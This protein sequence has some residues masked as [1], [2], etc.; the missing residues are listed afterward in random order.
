MR[1]L[2]GVRGWGS[3]AAAVTA[4]VACSIAGKQ[5]VE[6]HLLSA[7][8]G[9]GSEAR[10]FQFHWLRAAGCAEDVDIPL[11][12]ASVSN[13]MPLQLHAE[14]LWFVY[15]QSAL[16]RKR[17]V[18]PR[19]VIDDAVISASS[20]GALPRPPIDYEGDDSSVT[21]PSKP[22]CAQP[23]CDELLSL[24]SNLS[25]EKFVRGR[26]VSID[27]DMLAE[28]M[29]AHFANVH[30][31]AERLLSEARDIQQ[32]LAAL[33]NLLRHER[34]VIASR[35]R[36]EHLK[37]SLVTLK[38]HLARVDRMLNEEQARVRS[39]MLT[40]KQALQVSGQQFKLPSA[41]K[42]AHSTLQAM[43]MHCLREPAQ[44]S[45]VLTNLMNKPFAA[46][47]PSRGSNLR[48]IDSS[49]SV[50]E[51]SSARLTGT[52]DMGGNVLPFTAA[53]SF[54]ILP[55]P[56]AIATNQTSEGARWQMSIGEG[57]KKIALEAHSRHATQGSAYVV[58]RA[59][60]PGRIQA[61]CDVVASSIN[62][63][64]TAEFRPWLSQGEHDQSVN[65]LTSSDTIRE[66]IVQALSAAERAPEVVEF[67]FDEL[68]T[69]PNVKVDDEAVDW[70]AQALDDSSSHTVAQHYENAASKLELHVQQRLE[71]I[72]RNV[73][74]SRNE[75]EQH[76]N[77]QLDEL[78][79]L[80]VNVIN[81]L[82]QRTGTDFAR[83]PSS[84]ILR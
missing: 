60:A 31:Q 18:L 20:S 58:V 43:L 52:L 3:L 79:K 64:G 2:R 33:D 13:A 6:R 42:L 15:D 41:S 45:L 62:G 36:L 57:T 19:V 38:S 82:Q 25:S 83:Q 11:T 68:A 54:R 10:Q 44:Y 81:N 78:R 76:L 66:L 77:Q 4:M 84:E 59:S 26:Q 46:Q 7:V 51:V 27:T 35:E 71:T 50:F 17:L 70:L 24:V 16:L 12:Q 73:A 28:R 49:L 67:K 80:Q 65:A 47:Q 69:E 63:S 14:Q 56:R 1:W 48:H 21:V 23:W 34:Q 8:L 22:W 61:K 37:G 29:Q 40:E 9:N 39:A 5:Y 55:G 32:Q 30:G 75:A 72:S 74:L 53:G